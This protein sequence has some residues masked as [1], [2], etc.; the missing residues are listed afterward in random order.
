MISDVLTSLNGDTYVCTHTYIGRPY[1]EPLDFY[2]HAVAHYFLGSL[3]SCES[4]TS[5]N[6]WQF[7]AAQ[8]NDYSDWHQQNPNLEADIF[9]ADQLV[10][11]KLS[12]FKLQHPKTLSPEY[13]ELFSVESSSS[14]WYHFRDPTALLVKTNSVT[15]QFATTRQALKLL[16]KLCLSTRQ[17]EAITSEFFLY[18]NDCNE[19]DAILTA[20]VDQRIIILTDNHMRTL[21]SA[22]S[23]SPIIDIP[24][25]IETSEQEKTL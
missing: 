7:I 3:F 24:T 8:C 18:D 16:D 25:A 20:L 11:G 23:H 13:N 19:I 22:K 17:I 15:C 10:Q 4:P 1:C 21:H 14:R 6:Q 9:I 2:N 5:R 12:I